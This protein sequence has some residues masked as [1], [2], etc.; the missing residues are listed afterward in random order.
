MD[1]VLLQFWLAALTG[2][3]ESNSA[4]QRL[5]WK[6]LVFVKVHVPMK[7]K[8]EY[9]KPGSICGDN[10]MMS[11]PC[12]YLDPKYSVAA[13]LKPRRGKFVTTGHLHSDE[14]LGL[15]STITSLIDLPSGG[16]V[17]TTSVFLSRHLQRV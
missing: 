9:Q 14:R 12:F 6:S 8:L 5:L 4:N 3:A 2:L 10:L 13:V 17:T 7:H 1:T 16:A 11:V 15:T